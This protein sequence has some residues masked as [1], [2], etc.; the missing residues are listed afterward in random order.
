MCTYSRNSLYNNLLYRQ[1]VSVAFLCRERSALLWIYECA[2]L[3]GKLLLWGN[4]AT[5][6]TKLSTSCH[7]FSR[8]NPVFPHFVA[9]NVSVV[10]TQ[11]G[12]GYQGA[13]SQIEYLAAAHFFCLAAFKCDCLHTSVMDVC[14]STASPSASAD[15]SNSYHTLTLFISV[16]TCKQLLLATSCF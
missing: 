16:F 9:V 15:T 5:N 1:H 6:G 2:E 7:I 4:T 8:R 13:S 3:P 10:L 12:F 14:L 11:R